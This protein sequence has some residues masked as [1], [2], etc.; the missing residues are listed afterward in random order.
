MKNIL[1]V[2][3]RD[4]WIGSFEGVQTVDP[5]DY[6]SHHDWEPRRGTRVYNLCR[7]YSYQSMG[8]YV[9][10]LAEARGQRPIPDVM[11]IQD[12]CGS[13]AVRLIPQ[14][15][16]ELI[17]NALR[18]LAT[19]E[20]VLSV[21]FGENLAKKYDRLSKELYSLFQAPLLRFKFSRRSKWRL[22]SASAIALSDV[23]EVHREFVAE[24]AQRHFARRLVSRPKRQA[25]RYD[26]AILHNPD[27]GD[28]AP[29]DEVALKKLIKAA[30]TAGIAAELITRHDSDRLLEFDALFIRETTAVS[31]HTYRLARRAEAA[32]MV[33]IDDP[34]SILRCTN[35][36][37]L[38]ELLARAKIPTPRT[39]VIHRRNAKHAAE[40]LSFPCV[41]KRPDSAFSQGVVKAGNDEE[42]QT[43]LAE[44]FLDSELVIAQ[45]FMRT[46]FDWR[47]GVLDQRAMFACK[48]HMARGHWQIAKHSSV[49]EKP[50]FG[51]FETVPIELAPRKAVNIA[52]KAANLIGNG[53]YGV[54]VKEVDGQFYIIEVN[55][56]PNLD[57]G[58]ED[59]VLREELYRRV[60]ESFVRRI[61]NSKQLAAN[62]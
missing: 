35:K 9:S 17:Q 50:Q 26:M 4:D 11:T 39:V 22:R 24:A 31:H 46:D 16:E 48:Y 36:V 57:S 6:L 60:M 20:F 14:F 13:A 54:D 2:E 29:S 32:G 37:Y 1:V 10:L 49:G 44:Y 40:L 5:S 18:S 33:V 7:S 21:Y 8:Y 62:R 34:L 38:S 27:E 19:D 42:L 51:K 12:L 59:A 52:V 56:N 3:T 55:D 41:L 58:V 53:L 45:E 28:L 23:P 61:E 30:A 25:T 47:I 15:L 43:R